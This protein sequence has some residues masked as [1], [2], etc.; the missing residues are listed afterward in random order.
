[1][2]G[3]ACTFSENKKNVKYIEFQLQQTEQCFILYFQSLNK[4]SSVP[5]VKENNFIASL[6]NVSH[7]GLFIKVTLDW[8]F[9][10]H[11]FYQSFNLKL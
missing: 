1:M 10:F 8:Y 11:N 3:T 5:K 6:T 7:F 2:V 9:S 4:S